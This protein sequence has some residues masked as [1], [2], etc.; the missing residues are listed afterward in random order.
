MKHI[1]FIT[2]FNF[3]TLISGYA[4]PSGP[5][6]TTLPII[7]CHSNVPSFNV[8]LS[9]GNTLWYADSAV[10]RYGDPNFPCETCVDAN[11]LSPDNEKCIQFVVTVDE[12]ITELGFFDGGWSTLELRIMDTFNNTYTAPFTEIVPIDSAGTYFISYCSAGNSPRLY[13]IQAST[14]LTIEKDTMN[15]CGS[16]C[17]VPLNTCDTNYNKYSWHTTNGTGTF[18]FIDSCETEYCGSSQDSI[19]GSVLLICKK[20]D[21]LIC[22]TCV[23]AIDSIRL[24]FLAKSYVTDIQTACESY[25]W[26]DGNTYT[27]SNNTATDT[28]TNSIGCDSIITLNLTVN[29]TTFFPAIISNFIL[30]GDSIL[31]NG[32]YQTA[33]GEYYD[34]LANSNGCDSIIIYAVGFIINNMEDWK[35]NFIRV[36]PNPFTDNTNIEIQNLNG[37]TAYLSLCDIMGKEILNLNTTSNNTQI[38]RSNLTNG[39]YF[40][41]VQ[42]GNDYQSY[43]LIIK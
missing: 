37:E 21:T 19:N 22:D 40:L 5:P 13:F 6:C 3:L 27:T 20:Y 38:N 2:L 36:Y 26:I 1:I 4:Q 12:H 32:Q 28:L 41:K 35:E 29:N 30:E 43:K 17:S 25:T 33:S 34:T 42:I 24:N 11:V 10:S 9:I 18:T 15:W 31:I 8:D 39:I 16:V 14:S 7:P 23:L